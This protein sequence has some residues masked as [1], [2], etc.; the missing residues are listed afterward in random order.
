VALPAFRLTVAV[1]T[2]DRPHLLDQAL[3]S[4]QEACR[5]TTTPV[6]VLVVDNASPGD[7]SDVARRYAG[8][9]PNFRYECQASNIGGEANFFSCIE[10]AS[11]AHVW[12]VG[13]DDVVEPESVE[14]ILGML[15]EGANAVVVNYSVW[16]SDMQM[17]LKYAF[18]AES[19][20]KVF[21]SVDRVLETCGGGLGFTAA[22]V[23]NR[24]QVLKN[25]RDEFMRC[26]DIGLAFLDS[27]YRS[28]V[29]TRVA[30]L[31]VPLVKNRGDNSRDLRLGTVGWSS[32]S[33][34]R[35]FVI[36][37]HQVLAGL[38]GQGYSRRAVRRARN[39]SVRLYVP[40]R[41]RF[42]RRTRESC[43]ATIKCLVQNV[44][45]VPSLWT[46]AL[47]ML[48]V[49]RTVLRVTPWLRQFLL[50]HATSSRPKP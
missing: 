6:E 48:L 26:A 28:L 13:D 39:M 7:T 49:P 17:C 42:L 19:S 24:D 31:A 1:P 33:W 37:F 8:V 27:A 23:L 12:V 40:E 21:E 25:G 36:G 10:K 45:D 16:S 20:N 4:I 50:R 5:R 44:Y 34:N 43:R 30:Y 3:A 29:G 35:V 47:P 41:L 32:E 46:H 18:F 22:V 9:I 15:C 14:A 38:S 2:Y 11:G